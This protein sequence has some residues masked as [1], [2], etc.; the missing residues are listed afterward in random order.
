MQ[1]EHNEGRKALGAEVGEKHTKGGQF[2]KKTRVAHFSLY[3][4]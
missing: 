1:L 2:S 4:R 3:F